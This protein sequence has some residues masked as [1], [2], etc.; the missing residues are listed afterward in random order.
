MNQESSNSS[1]DQPR[2]RG[3]SGASAKLYQVAYVR[4]SEQAGSVEQQQFSQPATQEFASVEE[5]LRFDASQIETP[6][7]LAVRLKN[8][9][10]LEAKSARAWW[11]RM[12]AK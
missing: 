5:M 3:P 8:S 2:A 6:P 10:A 1:S 9:L 7:S 12:F 4:E 11:R